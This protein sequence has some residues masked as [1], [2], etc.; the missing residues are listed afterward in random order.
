MNDKAI[1]KP[2]IE[3]ILLLASRPEEEEK[4]VLWARHQALQKTDRIP[5]C[6]YYEGIPNAQ[7][8]LMFGKDLVSCSS[9]VGQEIELYLKKVIWMAENVPDDHIVWPMVLLRVPFILEQDWGVCL[10]MVH[11]GEELGAKAFAMPFKDKIELEKLRMPRIS[12]DKKAWEAKKQQAMELL[13]GQLDIYSNHHNL[14][15]APFDIVANLCG[16]ESSMMYAI[17]NPEELHKLMDFV[18]TALEEHHLKRA[19]EGQINF[20]PDRTKRFQIHTGFRLHCTYLPEENEGKP[21]LQFEWPYV[22]AQTS[23]GYGPEMFSEFVH[24]YN[25]RLARHFTDKTVYYHGCENLDQKITCIQNLPNLRRFHVS[26][27]SSVSKAA[28]ILQGKVVMEVHS[29]PGKVFF[30]WTTSDMSKDIANL[31][32]QSQGFSMDLNLSDI[33]S[34]NNN[35][36]ILGMWARVAKELSY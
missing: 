5:V 25:C 26:P 12:I 13:D 16:L 21:K 4:K 15:F 10:D 18:T 24:P 17:D 28:E 11:T 8:N 35:P 3:K 31:I 2:L 7:W 22:T 14:G 27:W 32:K 29:H 33:H 36:T 19:E 20:L 30:G 1:L 6:V 34:L 9:S 23:S